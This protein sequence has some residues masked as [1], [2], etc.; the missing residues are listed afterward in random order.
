VLP[1]LS[2]WQL[3][4]QACDDE[5]IMI[6]DK[7][8]IHTLKE[9]KQRGEP[10]VMLT[11]SDYPSALALD[12]SGVDAI[13]VG[14]TLAMVALGYDTTLAVTMD[15][16]LHHAKAVARGA[17]RAHLIGDMPFMSYQPSAAEAVRNAGRY[18]QEANMNAV[19]LEGGRAQTKTIRAIVQSGIPVMGHIGLTPQ[20]VNAMGGW[21]VQGR[22]VQTA[23]KLI[24]D[25]QVLQDAGCYAIVLE[26]IPDRL[27]EWITRH[28][29]IPTIGI[30]AGVGCDGQ[31]LVT[32]DVL[33]MF[34]R[35]TPKFVRRYANLGEAMSAAFTAY[36]DDVRARRFPSS[37]HV[38]SISDD[39]WT[40]VQTQLERTF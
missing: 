24:E 29:E 30:G 3:Q 20:S 26:A 15:D 9:K 33:G 6:E 39:A 17:K 5:Q 25:A 35:F 1:I 38:F 23:I 7:V 16:M 36:A 34:D 22:G 14:D 4:L 27:A 18:L 19:K 2:A 13:L 8:T 32:H 21:K 11:A 37:E 28:L 40:E 31:V 10:I 12:R